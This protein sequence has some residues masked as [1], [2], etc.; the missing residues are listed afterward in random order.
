MLKRFA[1]LNNSLVKVLSTILSCRLHV[2][3]ENGRFITKVWL[4]KK[5]FEYLC[6]LN[7]RK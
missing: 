4:D 6:T 5:F 1:L 7:D 2:L 3:S